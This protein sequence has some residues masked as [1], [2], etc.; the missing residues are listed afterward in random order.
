MN[1]A[2]TSQIARLRTCADR[3]N[4]I[5]AHVHNNSQHTSPKACGSKWESSFWNISTVI[6]APLRRCVD[7][8]DDYNGQE[9]LFIIAPHAGAWI[10]IRPYLATGWEQ[11]SHSTDRHKCRSDHTSAWIEMTMYV[12]VQLQ[13]ISHL[14]IGAWIETSQRTHN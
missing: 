4:P 1:Y 7:W 12:V 11:I 2:V 13:F 14:S 3:N 10:E 9:I 6:I 8:N 5:F